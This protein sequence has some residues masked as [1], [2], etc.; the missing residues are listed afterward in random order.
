MAKIHRG[1][2]DSFKKLEEYKGLTSLQKKFF[3]EF[4]SGKNIFLTGPAGT[5]K[6]FCVN[7]LFKFL[8]L[9]GIFY[10]KTATTGVAALNIGGTTVHSWSGMG[11]ADD[12]GM[13]LL[14]KVNENKK[15]VNRIKN[16]K[17]LVIDEISMAKSELVDKLDIVCQYIRN[18]DKPFGG[19]QV[20]F[21]G[22]FMQLPPI[23]KNYER[24]VF[25]FESQAWREATV[26]TIHLTEIVRQHDDPEFA[27]LLNEVRMASA[28]DF[29]LLMSCIDRKFPNDGI[30]P[31]KLYCKNIDVSKYN[32]EELHK[33][34]SE[35]QFYHA[36]DSG[37]EQWAKFFEKNCPAPTDL[38]LRI[39][40]QVILLVNV[41]V[42]A[43]LVNGSVGV[44]TAMHE[45][46]VEVN[47]ACG[48]HVLEM[49]K[50]EIKQNEF[51][52]LN[53]KMKKVTLASRRQIPLKL[54][55]A[56]TIHKCLEKNS[57]L[58]LKN[59]AK[60]IG[61]VGND[62]TYSVKNSH[63][64]IKRIHNMLNQDAIKLTLHSGKEIICSP[65]HRIGVMYSL[66]KIAFEEAFSIKEGDNILS[67]KGFPTPEKSPVSTELCWMLGALVGDGSYSQNSIDRGN[68]RIDF[69]NIPSECGN[70]YKKLVE[71]LLNV[72]VSVTKP[73]N[74]MAKTFYFHSKE[75]REYL[76]S[77]GLTPATR[78]NKRV[79]KIIFECSRD[80]I[81]NFLC[82]LIDS[83]GH[84]NKRNIVITNVA[85]QMLLETQTLFEILGYRS[86]LAAT[87]KKKIKNQNDKYQLQVY[88]YEAR[89]FLTEFSKYLKAQ[90]KYKH[91][92]R[93]LAYPYKKNKVQ[94]NDLP[95][96]YEEI[97]SLRLELKPKF[98]KPYGRSYRL[99]LPNNLHDFL[100]NNRPGL[101]RFV[102]ERMV[103]EIPSFSTLGP[104]ARAIESATAS[105]LFMDTV[106]SVEPVFNCNLVDIT[107][108]KEHTYFAN[109][110][111]HHNCQGSTLDRAEI[112]VEDAFACGQV[113]VALSRVRNL[114]SLKIL[115][116]APHKITAN[117]KCLNFYRLQEEKK[118]VEF[119]IEED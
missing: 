103:R 65:N 22:D 13:E 6:S 69:T 30:K 11:L 53:G 79:P 106:V 61:N 35:S 77:L 26:K 41:D 29:T 52:T 78:E 95:L 80:G 97:E 96:T 21:V 25:A 86:F 62:Y 68:Y 89:R 40:A 72:K 110:V 74:N 42:P 49:Y 50:W 16:A 67:K 104:V 101:D 81:A 38:E 24:E 12:D 37:G 87:G 60:M 55:W 18:K 117:E 116:F 3:R 107:V 5:G 82:G 73:K 83:D 33:I 19:I 109:G 108:D 32:H 39:G 102:L 70:T 91:L 4:F 75:I 85:K 20:V 7:L 43:G 27:K 9:Q 36:V 63:N 28:D 54:A 34:K 92:T 1:L 44:V 66:T 14:E 71:S 111:F 64:K 31:V 118:E 84:I 58:H 113:Y 56:L 119:F 47:F 45:N 105:N 100:S 114:A 57:I 23:F 112:N 99:R 94:I 59:S 90:G 76:S 46:S 115:S 48:P 15:A 8:D 93:L 88:S 2:F 98:G 10:G 17:V 51:D